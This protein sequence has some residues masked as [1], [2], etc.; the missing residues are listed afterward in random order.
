MPGE[1]FRFRCIDCDKERIS[2]KAFPPPRGWRWGV[3]QKPRQD[4]RSGW[5]CSE[6][7][8]RVPCRR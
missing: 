1:T 5:L 2:L 3:T 8:Q 6:C 4:L 7:A